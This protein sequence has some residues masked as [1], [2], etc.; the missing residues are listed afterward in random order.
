[1]LWTLPSLWAAAHLIVTMHPLANTSR[2]MARWVSSS[3]S[4]LAAKMT[5]WSPTMSPARTEWT[6]ISR[7]LG[8]TTPFLP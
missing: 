8:P 5:V 1:M 3:I 4:P 6:P 2:D 7:C